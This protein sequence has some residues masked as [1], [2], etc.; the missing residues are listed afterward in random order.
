MATLKNIVNGGQDVSWLE[1]LDSDASRWKFHKAGP[2]KDEGVVHVY[3]HEGG[4]LE[5]TPDGL[6]LQQEGP[7]LPRTMNVRLSGKRTPAMPGGG[8]L[9]RIG[10]QGVFAFEQES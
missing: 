2:A 6:R 3:Q 10:D 9:A 4:T 8:V 1:A 5:I 7:G